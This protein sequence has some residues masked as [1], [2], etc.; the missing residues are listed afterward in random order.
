MNANA[1]PGASPSATLT[2]K[3]VDALR[4]LR[5][6]NRRNTLS[7]GVLAG[8]LWPDRL[9]ECGTSRRRS[10]LYRAAGAYYSRLKKAGLVGHWID[11]SADTAAG[12]YLTAAGRAI[13]DEHD[14]T[15]ASRLTVGGV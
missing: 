10:G 9:H 1:M 3:A 13:L 12:Y 4:R 5:G 8:L 11:E 14:A 7:A 6:T 15:E 2:P